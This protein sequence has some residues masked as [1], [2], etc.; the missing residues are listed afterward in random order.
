M[1]DKIEQMILEKLKETPK[2][3]GFD[4][5]PFP[6]NF[7]KFGFKSERGCLLVKYDGSE[8]TKPETINFVRQDETLEFSVMAGFRYVR[9]LQETYP[10]VEEIRKV[11]T[12]MNIFGRKLYPKKRQYIGHVKGDLYYGY[13]FAVTVPSTEETIPF[14]TIN[15]FAE[16]NEKQLAG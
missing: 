4:V 2:F 7:D 11:L 13:V 14:P 12:G 16:S 8:F 15:P 1:F 6:E 10:A 3:K 5:L 9:T